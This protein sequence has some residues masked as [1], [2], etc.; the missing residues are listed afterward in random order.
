MSRIDAVRNAINAI[1]DPCSVAMTEPIGLAD[2]GIIERVEIE[3]D[4]VEVT[5]L[6]TSPHCLFLGLFEEEIERRVRALDWVRTVEVRLTEGL[7]IWDESRMSEAARERL[8]R[9]RRATAAVLAR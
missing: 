8:A 2:L 6:P 4:R 9:R 7:E 5:L 3:D 1:V